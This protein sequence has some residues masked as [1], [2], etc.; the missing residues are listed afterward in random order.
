MAAETDAQIKQDLIYL[1]NKRT[2]L[3]NAGIKMDDLYYSAMNSMVELSEC[4]FNLGRYTSSLS[5][6]SFG[7]T[8]QISIPNSSF[9]SGVY[10]TFRLPP[11]VDN[12]TLPRGWGYAF[13]KSVSYLFGSSNIS[14]IDLPQHVIFQTLMMECETSERRSSLLS[15]GGEE[16]LTPTTNNPVATIFIPLPFSSICG[17]AAKKPFD[18][19]IIDNPVTLQISLARADEVYGGSGVRPTGF[20]SAQLLL[21]MGDLSNKDQSLR[22]VLMKDPALMYSYPFIHRQQAGNLGNII[23]GSTDPNNRVSISL[24]SIINADL[25]GI[26]F[27]LVPLTKLSNIAGNTCPNPFAYDDLSNITLEF[28]GLIMYNSPNNLYKLANLA[29]TK[30]GAGFY[31]NSVISDGSLSP[32]T[33]NAQDNYVVFIDFSRIRTACFDGTYSNVWRIGNNA[34]TLS[35]N[36]STT[37]QYRIFATYHYNGVLEVQNGQTRIYFD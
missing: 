29:L 35:F 13:L 8:S 20:L 15:I 19:S 12:Q 24:I 25:V 21:R 32:F 33:S 1:A 10:I 36:T 18:S 34:L 11:V 26:S 4:T 30:G 31:S 16:I 3:S 14:Q 7:G 37:Q 9:Y 22:N 27:G 28:N 6:L 2:A 5:Q 23:Q 17:I